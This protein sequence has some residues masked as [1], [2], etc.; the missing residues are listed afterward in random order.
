[1]ALKY[2]Q[3][4][5]YSPQYSEKVIH[6]DLGAEICPKFLAENLSEKFFDGKVL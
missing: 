5:E 6:G 4:Q 2:L 3:I 1:M